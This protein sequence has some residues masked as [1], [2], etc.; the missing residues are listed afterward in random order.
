MKIELSDKLRHP[1]RKQTRKS[2]Q[3][4]DIK[5]E[6]YYKRNSD[7]K[8]KG[9]SKVIGQDGPFSVYQTWRLLRESSL[10]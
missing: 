4:F 3:F 6:V 8:Q 10:F 2:G 1:F 7:K 9:L 5:E